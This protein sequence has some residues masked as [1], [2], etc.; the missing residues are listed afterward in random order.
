MRSCIVGRSVVQYEKIYVLIVRGEE[1]KYTS[2]VRLKGWLVSRSLAL[3][4]VLK[5]CI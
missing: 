1:I 2:D 5:L 4:T 3:E